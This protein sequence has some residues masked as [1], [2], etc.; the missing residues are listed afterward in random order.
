M[1]LSPFKFVYE[2]FV[3]LLEAAFVYGLFLLTTFLIVVWMF[4]NPETITVT[5]YVHVP[6]IK[7][8]IKETVEPV[9]ECLRVEGC[10]LNY[11]AETLEEYCPD[12][13]IRR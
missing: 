1:I 3:F 2:L 7:T 10:V 4:A 13:I 5:E 12:C 9:L 6:V 8:V 11:A